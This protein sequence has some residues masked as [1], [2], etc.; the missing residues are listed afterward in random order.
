[1]TKDS[2]E[3]KPRLKCSF[4]GKTQE[5]VKKLIAGPG[6]YIC[7]EC[8]D[9]CNEIL[10]EEGVAIGTGEI[11]R[12]KGARNE[13]LSAAI[14]QSDS[15]IVKRSAESSKGVQVFVQNNPL[16]TTIEEKV[17][18]A[19]ALEDLVKDGCLQQCTNETYQ[20]TWK[21]LI[22]VSYTH[23]DVYKRQGS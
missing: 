14:T 9:L 3:D 21:G 22:A 19:S 10:R 13:I 17:L 4:C 7:D 6:V 18:Y 8:V 5:M 1:M 23:L 15:W 20:V 11:G 16:G 2:S 12:L